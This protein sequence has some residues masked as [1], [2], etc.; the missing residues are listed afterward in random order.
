[1]SKWTRILIALAA[2]DAVLL[3]SRALPVFTSLLTNVLVLVAFFAIARY[4]LRQSRALWRVRNRLIVTYVFIAVV[5]ILLILALVGMSAYIV[6]GQV[7]S[8]LV[9]S[10]ASR[11][12]AALGGPARIL[13]DLEPARRGP[14]VDAIIPFLRDRMPGLQVLVTGVQ[15]LHSPPDSTLQAPPS[16]WQPYTGLVRKDGQFYF[17]SLARSGDCQVVMLA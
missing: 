3:A 11:R 16:G 7:A 9:S 17:M 12:A 2:L 10:E 15:T 8:Y 13:S 1:M 6:S 4:L 14:V 5:P